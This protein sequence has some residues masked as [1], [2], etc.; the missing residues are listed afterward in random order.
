MRLFLRFFN[1]IR[2][3]FRRGVADEELDRELQS[4]LEAAVDASAGPRP[5]SASCAP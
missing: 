3:L 4:F 5:C 1:G 2:T